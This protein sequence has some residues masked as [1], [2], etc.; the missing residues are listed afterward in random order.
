MFT[1]KGVDTACMLLTCQAWC[2]LICIDR[3]NDAAIHITPQFQAL[4]CKTSFGLL[5]CFCCLFGLSSLEIPRT[6]LSHQGF[7]L[8]QQALRF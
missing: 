5:D 8:R 1:L 6:Y 7:C 2:V 3:N 4:G